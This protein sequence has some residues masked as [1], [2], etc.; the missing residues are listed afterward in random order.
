MHV[1][2]GEFGIDALS[3]YARTVVDSGEAVRRLGREK[4]SA[5]TQRQ[6]G[7][8]SAAKPRDDGQDATLPCVFG[9]VYCSWD[10]VAEIV[11]PVR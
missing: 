2:H 7:S 8:H 1:W 10:S 6:V 4:A 11:E 9:V 5:A 3:F